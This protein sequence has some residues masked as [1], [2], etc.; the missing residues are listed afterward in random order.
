MSLL[1]EMLAAASKAP[2]TLGANSTRL[3][4]RFLLGQRN[5]NGGFK[6]RAGKSDL[7][8]TTFGLAG[9]GALMAASETVEYVDG[10]DTW[11]AFGRAGEFLSDFADGEGLDFVHLCSL[12]RA[13]GA[14]AALEFLGQKPNLARE[15]LL[16]RIEQFRA[17]NGGYNPIQGAELGTAYG[18]Y[19]GLGAYQD[20]GTPFPDE[21]RLAASLEPLRTPD[22]AWTNE[23]REMPQLNGATNATAA[24]LGVLRHVGF[25]PPSTAQ[26]WLLARAHPKGG[27]MATPTAPLPDLLSTASA[28]HSLA[29]LGAP[30]EPVRS[31]C[32]D[33][34][35]S[36]WTNAGGFHGHWGDDF[37][38]VEYTFYGLLALG[39]LTR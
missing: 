25:A 35:D 38:D 8:Y 16:A 33:F 19:L 18:A 24:A 10:K 17:R 30:F 3:V 20:L 32:L 21:G 29:M 7:Y 34:I 31:K 5:A 27:F 1:M 9:L 39:H 14:M 2:A 4:G 23:K 36:L 28:L 11:E 37:L 26:N 12:A 13:R 6:D 15:R 22:G